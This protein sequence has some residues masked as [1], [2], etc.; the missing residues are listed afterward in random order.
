MAT[1]L[2]RAERLGAKITKRKMMGASVYRVVCSA[3]PDLYSSNYSSRNIRAGMNDHARVHIARGAVVTPT[4]DELEAAIAVGDQ[5][6][7]GPPAEPL[8]PDEPIEATVGVTMSLGHGHGGPRWYLRFTDQATGMQ[9]LEV[10]MSPEQFGT[11]VGHTHTRDCS[12]RMPT[13][14]AL[15]FTG[16]HKEVK[17]I[18]VP[19]PAYGELDAVRRAA[20]AHC[21]NGWRLNDQLDTWNGHRHARGLYR[22]SLFRYVDP[23]QTS[24]EE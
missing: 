23:P 13:L 8:D 4:P 5:P 7:E 11:A 18:R 6:A 14:N 12:A 3:C 16:K 2:E 20:E 19:C 10:E 24:E 15:R 17:T 9:L 22:V 21:V 1:L